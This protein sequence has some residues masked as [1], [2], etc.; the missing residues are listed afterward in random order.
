MQDLRAN[1]AETVSEQVRRTDIDHAAY[2]GLDVHKSTIAVAVAPAGRESPTHVGELANQPK[3][4][5]ERI[6]TDRRDA[7]KLARLLR[8]GELTPV[9]VPDEEQEA[10]RDLVRAR[11]DFKTAERKARQQLG[12]FLLRHGRHW[13]KSRWTQGHYAWLDKQRFDQDWQEWAFREY[14]DAVRA[15]SDKVAAVMGQ[16]E[17]ALPD[18]SM[19]PVV[20][21][22]IALRGVDTLTAMTLLAELGDVSRFDKPGQLM[23]YLG[24]VPSE[25]SSGS[26]RRQGGITRTGNGQARRALVE[27]AWCYRF[28]ARQTAHLKRKAAL[29]SEEAKTIAWKAQRRL[30]GRYRHLLKA[31][32]NSKQATVKRV[33]GKW[34]CVVCYEVAVEPRPDDGRVIGVDGNVGQVALSTG[35]LLRQPDTAR[36]EARR[37]RYQRMVSRRQKGS[38]RRDRARRRLAKVSRQIAMCRRNWHDHASRTIAD[39][40]GLVVVEDLRLKTMTKSAKGTAEAPG[41]NVSAKAGLNRSLLGTGLGD[42]GRRIEQKALAGRV[43]LRRVWLGKECRRECGDQHHGLGDWGLLGGEGR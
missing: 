25:H 43:P 34:F 27:S 4:P 14:L 30:C 22:L 28:P 38:N 15:A 13:S 21:S 42:L 2:V 32:K 9:W 23:A 11:A 20:R 6:K 40:A 10:M 24:L 18:W 5:G 16:L 41:R 19:E 7:C 17:R 8:S 39:S 37:R 33:C 12:A 3:A 36:L 26:R 35:H 1:A 29:A 31:G